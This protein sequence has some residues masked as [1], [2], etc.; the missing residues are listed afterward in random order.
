MRDSLKE[1]CIGLASNFSQSDD[2]LSRVVK[3]GLIHLLTWYWLLRFL[4]LHVKSP[5][6]ALLPSLHEILYHEWWFLALY[7]DASLAATLRAVYCTTGEVSTLSAK[8]CLLPPI[9]SQ[10]FYTY[11]LPLTRFSIFIGSS[12]YSATQFTRRCRRHEFH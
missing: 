12:G 2:A 9:D 5:A 11:S 7:F 10:L 8:W 1:L 3:V 4:M 6:I